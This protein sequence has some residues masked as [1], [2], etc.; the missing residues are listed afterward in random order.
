MDVRVLYQAASIALRY[1][2]DEVLAQ[3]PL[4]AEALAEQQVTGFDDLLDFW[5]RESAQDVQKHYID[6]FDLS[7]KRTLYLSFYLDGDTRRRGGTLVGF[8]RRY[9]DSGALVD[10]H[11]ELPDFLP[12]ALE[13]A[14]LIDTADGALMLQENRRGLELLRLALR[15]YRTCYAGVVEAICGTLPGPSPQDREAVMAMAWSGPPTEQVG[16]EPY[17][18]RLLPMGGP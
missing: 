14:A 16:L 3:M 12:L 9:R 1:P 15:D 7:R 13:Y 10:T 18:P 17:D 6:V 5:A 8:K 11:G 4:L 2:D